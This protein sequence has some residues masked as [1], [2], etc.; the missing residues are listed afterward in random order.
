MSIAENNRASIG[1][2][3]AWDS[4]WRGTGE[5][6]AYKQH[7]P[8]E[9]VLAQ[10][11]TKLFIAEIPRYT[12]PRLVDLACGNGV[13]TQFLHDAITHLGTARYSIHCVDSSP[14]AIAALTKRFA[15]V[16]GVVSTGARTGSETVA[17]TRGRAPSL[18]ENVP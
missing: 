13:V 17:S 9:R 16:S 7:S 12:Q 5:K 11:W 1:Q 15:S 2:S 6:A 4:F 3:S 10:F 8:L 14:A 18:P